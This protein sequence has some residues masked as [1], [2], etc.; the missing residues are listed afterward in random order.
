MRFSTPID[1]VL[2]N[3]DICNSALPQWGQGVRR[4]TREGMVVARAKGKLKGNLSYNR[5]DQARAKLFADAF[6][7]VGLNVWWDTALRSGEAHDEVTETAL[8]AAKAVVVPW[9]PRSVVSRWVRAEATIADRCKTLVPVTIEPYERPIMF[10]LT[11]TAELSHWT[12]DVADKAWLAFLDDV[13]RMA[14]K[15]VPPIHQTPATTV[16]APTV[17]ECASRA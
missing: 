9:S 13:R 1:A 8:R 14:A 17:A 7:A 3:Y 5:E 12:G 2:S 11:Q 16:T 6:A 4:G 10:E 15:A